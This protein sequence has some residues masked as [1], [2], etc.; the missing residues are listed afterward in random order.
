MSRGGAAPSPSACCFSGPGCRDLAYALD[1]FRTVCNRTGLYGVTIHTD[2]PLQINTTS[3]GKL[4]AIGNPDSKPGDPRKTLTFQGAK[5][6]TALTFDNVTVQSVNVIVRRMNVVTSACN[7][8]YVSLTSND[9][10]FMNIS[11][12]NRSHVTSLAALMTANVTNVKISNWT[13]NDT[14]I[15][16]SG[17]AMII[18]VR[19]AGSVEMRDVTV[20][21][22]NSTSPCPGHVI[23][24]FNVSTCALDHVSVTNTRNIGGVR[25]EN[26][27]GKATIRKSTFRQV[28]NG[29]GDAA[30]SIINSSVRVEHSHF[31]ENAGAATLF[32]VDSQ[33]HVAHCEIQNNPSNISSSFSTFGAITVMSSR[34]LSLGAHVN[35][36]DLHNDAVSDIACL[37][38]LRRTNASRNSAY[39]GGAVAILP[40]CEL[41]ISDG[42]RF[43]SN[44]ASFG[45]ALYIDTANKPDEQGTNATK[46]SHVIKDAAMFR[47][48]SAYVSG[49]AVFYGCR[50]AVAQSGLGSTH[51]N[52]QFDSS[53]LLVDGV[54]FIG[55]KAAAPDNS[56]DSVGGAV[57]SYANSTFVNC[58]FEQNRAV[59][60]GS[61]FLY[62][63][64]C[65]ITGNTIFTSDL[66]C[67]SGHAI[68]A[69]VSEVTI[70]GSHFRYTSGLNKKNC[71]G[72]CLTGTRPLVFVNSWVEAQDLSVHVDVPVASANETKPR[73]AHLMELVVDPY[74]HQLPTQN[75]T[76]AK[77]RNVTFSCSKNYRV[78]IWSGVQFSNGC[79][80][81]ELSSDG[82][83]C[84][85]RSADIVC[86]LAYRGMYVVD[87]RFVIKRN[88]DSSVLNSYFVNGEFIPCPAGA[89][90][91]TDEGIVAR[92]GYW[93]IEESASSGE[94]NTKIS[95]TRCPPDICCEGESCTTYNSCNEEF[96]RNSTSLLCSECEK[97]YCELLFS[98][99]CV[100][101]T[102]CARAEKRSILIVVFGTLGLVV[103]VAVVTLT[104]KMDETRALYSVFHAMLNKHFGAHKHAAPTH[105]KV[106][107]V[108]G[109]E[110][111]HA[112]YPA[113][114]MEG[115]LD[116]AES[117]A[118]SGK[119][120]DKAHRERDQAHQKSNT[121]QL[122]VRVRRLLW[123]LESRLKIVF[124]LPY[125][126]ITIFF[127]QDSEV[128]DMIESSCTQDDHYLEWVDTHSLTNLFKLDIDFLHIFSPFNMTC[129]PSLAHNYVAK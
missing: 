46:T 5:Q 34:D 79:N 112:D 69:Q 30:V 14:D 96:K 116:A 3:L 110:R 82:F 113:E 91:S 78:Y 66:P 45:G 11:G 49:G 86:E 106:L 89:D 101:C 9:A 84:V 10:D 42:C 50:S 94:Y 70:N 98:R 17:G 55:N 37:L 102:E 44:E 115:A 43:E 71:E 90:C 127:T 73:Q 38:S 13:L 68:H 1:Q 12:D 122:A 23:S 85:D 61:L 22:V 93:G 111:V 19:H 109:R 97:G 16:S 114:D 60:G 2:L 6:V 57:A 81:T 56:G 39:L 41:R 36:P 47:N 33:L 117:L 64:T 92:D 31:R 51:P 27:T 99:K 58:S 18:D 74:P 83:C 75:V 126:I 123:A 48:N 7:F 8:K 108:R 121:S 80:K 129:F 120:S 62:E 118:E 25:L 63:T 76:R 4:Q 65:T 77:L 105:K 15:M 54:L 107:S 21:N 87:S 32:A 128:L 67:F 29:P 119:E 72:S 26:V 59:T 88:L 53:E 125:I 103:V 24:I 95:M 35:S 28:E 20:H 52:C 124:V 104:G 100:N 40:S